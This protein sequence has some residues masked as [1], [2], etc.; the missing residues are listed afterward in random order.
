MNPLSPLEA[1]PS[2]EA[3]GYLFAV[4]AVLYLD[5]SGYLLAVVGILAFLAVVKDALRLG[6]EIQEELDE[7]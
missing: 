1:L 7:L 3:L 2:S 4:G 5:L 6:R